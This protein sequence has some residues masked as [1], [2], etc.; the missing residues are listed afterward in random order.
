MTNPLG[1]IVSKAT[2]EAFV[3]R[4]VC[5][6]WTLLDKTN[7]HVIQERMPPDTFELRHVHDQ[8][9]QLYFILEGRATVERAGDTF[10]VQATEAIE[11][12][13]GVPHQMRNDSQEPVEFL[14]ISSQRPR[15]DRR[16]LSEV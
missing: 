10:E 5:Q 12:P 7:L 16:G 13:A 9:N 15:E 6:G 2:T 11:V 1:T 3:W 4:D 14:V 8:T